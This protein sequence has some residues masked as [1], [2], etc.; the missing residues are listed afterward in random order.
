MDTHGIENLSRRDFLIKG[1]AASAG[2]TL[3]LYLPR[4]VGAAYRL[5]L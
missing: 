5:K 4:G 2:S 1:L 3:G